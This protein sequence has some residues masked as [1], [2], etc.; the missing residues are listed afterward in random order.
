MKTLVSILILSFIFASLTLRGHAEGHKKEAGPNGGRIVEAVDPHFE[1]FVLPDGIVQLT[2]LD[3][4]GKPIPP[5]QQEV[6]AVTGSRAAPTML[7]FA[8]KEGV[9]LADKPL[10]D[11]QKLPIILTIKTKPGEKVVRERFL[12]NFSSCPT[13]DYVEYA[14]VCGHEDG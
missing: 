13:C 3:K 5:A 10:P 2:Y 6:T 1:F 12:V 8:E 11:G 7:S 14:C 9:L 4:S